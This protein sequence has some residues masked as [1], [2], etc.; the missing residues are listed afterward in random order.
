VETEW[1]FL[2]ERSEVMVNVTGIYDEDL[3]NVLAEIEEAYTWT[4]ATFETGSFEGEVTQ[5]MYLLGATKRS[6]GSN[7]GTSSGSATGRTTA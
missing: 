7:S 4:G 2:S 6:N 5:W 3:V 1:C